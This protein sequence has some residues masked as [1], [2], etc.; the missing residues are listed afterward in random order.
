M[1]SAYRLSEIIDDLSLEK[2]QLEG[3]AQEYEVFVERMRHLV[4]TK[5]VTTENI[6]KALED[7][8]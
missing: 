3:R 4:D 6:T 8:E 5:M 7:V 1:L 2:E